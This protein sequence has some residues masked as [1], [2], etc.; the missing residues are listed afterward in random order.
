[1]C[2][3]DLK[4]Q[5]LGKK[6][7]KE[8]IAIES[9]FESIMGQFSDHVCEDCGNP[10]WRTFTESEKQKGLDG[11]ACWKGYRRQGTKMKG[12]RRVDNCVKVS[13]AVEPIDPTAR[14]SMDMISQILTNMRQR[15]RIKNNAKDA[16]T[17][18][19]EHN[20]NKHG[21]TA[22]VALKIANRIAQRRTDLPHDFEHAF[23][24]SLRNKLDRSYLYK[25]EAVNEM[26][27]KMT[28]QG[29]SKADIK[30]EKPKT[31]LGEFILSYFDRETGKFPK[32]ETAVLTAVEKDY[33]DHYVEPARQFIE[34]VQATTL[35]YIQSEESQSRYPE[36]A[37]IK[38]LAGF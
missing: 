18:S 30:P 17:A 9:A 7:T 29:M 4:D 21:A 1:V 25:K 23:E 2:S 31:P 19:F 3:S 26:D 6:K 37:A 5:L 38:R 15:Q 13:E 36:T 24:Q 35:E 33:G 28:P 34:Q 22:G 11:K 20:L 27:V 14:V 32:G 12:G 10:S 8:E 16:M